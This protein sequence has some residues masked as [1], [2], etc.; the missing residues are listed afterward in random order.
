M[1]IFVPPLPPGPAFTGPD[2]SAGEAALERIMDDGCTVQRD[3]SGTD[4]A[5]LDQN[6]GELVQ[7]GLALVYLGKCMFRGPAGG[8][9]VVRGDQVAVQSDPTARLPLSWFRL[10]PAQE[11][12]RGDLLT[13]TSSRRDPSTIGQVFEVKDIAAATITVARTLTLTFRGF[14]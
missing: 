3:V 11:P 2:L 8:G 10:N 7:A 5:V 4:E 14:R 6:T 1:P 9:V 12:R 13:I